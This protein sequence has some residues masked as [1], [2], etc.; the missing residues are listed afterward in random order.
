MMYRIFAVAMLCLVSMMTTSLSAQKAKRGTLYGWMVVVDPGHGGMD[1]GSSRRHGNGQIF[2]ASYVYDVALRV[3][4]LV[5]G[6][7]WNR[8]LYRP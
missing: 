7:F 5:P 4:R 6:A 8:F 2:E 1:P 3:Q